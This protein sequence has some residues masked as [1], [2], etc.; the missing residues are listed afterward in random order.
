MKPLS[1][2]SA[3]T[4]YY[5]ILQG[6]TERIESG[7]IGVGDRLKFCHCGSAGQ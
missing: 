3:G 4:L 5:Q 1:R 2:T 6:L 7:E